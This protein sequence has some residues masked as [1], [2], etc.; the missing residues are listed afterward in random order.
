MK[1]FRES[2]LVALVLLLISVGCVTA[3]TYRAVKN[4]KA[5]PDI[6]APLTDNEQAILLKIIIIVPKV[7]LELAKRIAKVVNEMTCVNANLILSMI[8]HESNFKP[9]VVSPKGAMGLMQVLEQWL[10]FMHLPGPPTDIYTNIKCG[11]AVL[12]IYQDWFKDLR[13]ALIAYNRGPNP[14]HTAIVNGVDPDNGYAEKVL[15]L[16]ARLDSYDI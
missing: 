4:I 7:E 6:I 9:E 1:L 11:V 15:K 10:E 5:C 13:L 14:V 12:N 16:K 8:F 2:S 3:M